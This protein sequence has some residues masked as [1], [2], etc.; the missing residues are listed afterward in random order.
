MGF[1][2]YSDITVNSSVM[3]MRRQSYFL[4]DIVVLWGKMYQLNNMKKR[5][6]DNASETETENL[7]TWDYCKTIE[8]RSKLKSYR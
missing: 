1:Q 4:I 2:H 3:S 8:G 6:I 5:F 7:S